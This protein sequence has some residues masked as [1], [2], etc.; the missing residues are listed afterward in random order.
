MMSWPIKF[1]G[2]A[3]AHFGALGLGAFGHGLGQTL[4]GAGAGIERDQ[5]LGPLRSSR[6]FSGKQTMARLVCSEN[7]DIIEHYCSGKLNMEPRSPTLDQISVFLAIV[8]TGSFAAAARKL[9]RAT[10]VMSYAIANLESQLGVSLFARAGA[11]KPRLTEAGRAILSDG[12]GM[13]HGAGW[14]DRQGARPDPGAGSGSRA[15]WWM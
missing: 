11:G 1:A 10:S 6:R 2:P 7:W 8:E 3:Q 5:D 14:A 15:W 12:R 9:G 4:D 13:A